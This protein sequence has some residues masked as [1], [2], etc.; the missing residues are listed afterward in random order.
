MS[1][2]NDDLVLFHGCTNYALQPHNAQGIAI[3]SL[4]HGISPAVGA[5]KPDF[6]PGF[7]ATTWLRQ[8]KNWANLRVRKERSRYSNPIATVLRFT[9]KRDDLA[10]LESLVFVSERGDYFPFVGY[11]RAGMRPH[12]PNS[13]RS[14]PYDIVYGPISLLGQTH[15]INNSDQIC[16]HTFNATGKISTVSIE[17]QG[18]PLFDDVVP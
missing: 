2:Q 8:A 16:F 4:P 14:R 5:K 12:A 6:G 3:G 11:C 9:A 10:S 1:W 18:S 13:N 15:T 7:Y 17:S